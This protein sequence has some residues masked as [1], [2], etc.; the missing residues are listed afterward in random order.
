MANGIRESRPTSLLKDSAKLKAVVNYHIVSR[1]LFAQ[2]VK[3]PECFWKA[4][5]RGLHLRLRLASS[6]VARRN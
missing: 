1:H 4:P 2:D 5:G 3:P 6:F